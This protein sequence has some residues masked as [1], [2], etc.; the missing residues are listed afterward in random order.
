[1]F[2]KTIYHAGDRMEDKVRGKLSHYPL[3]YAFIGGVGAVV[4]WRGVWHTADYVMEYFFAVGD[5]V[6]STSAM[7]LPWWDGPVSM[8]VGTIL[9]L[10]V[11]LFV[12]NFIGNEIIISGLRGEKKLIEKTQKEVEEDLLFDNKIKKEIHEIDVRLEEIEKL[13][14]KTESSSHT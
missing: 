13:L 5:T 3:L 2:F 9:L 8:L 14:H 11:G 12:S 1:M 10:A 7:Q 4:F 6:S